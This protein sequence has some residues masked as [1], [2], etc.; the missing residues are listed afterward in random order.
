MMS[1]AISEPRLTVYR[2]RRSNN[3]F[4]FDSYVMVGSSSRQSHSAIEWGVVVSHSIA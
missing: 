3:Q 1:S 2:V 4:N